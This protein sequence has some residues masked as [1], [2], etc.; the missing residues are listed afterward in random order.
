[1]VLGTPRFSGASPRDLRTFCT[2]LPAPVDSIAALDADRRG[3]SRHASSRLSAL[4]L[5]AATVLAVGPRGPGVAS[6]QAVAYRWG[7][8]GRATV[9]ARAGHRPAHRGRGTPPGA[10]QLPCRPA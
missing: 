1:M 7:R 8:D 6:F 2:W 10:G 5:T 9:S 4:G 3:G